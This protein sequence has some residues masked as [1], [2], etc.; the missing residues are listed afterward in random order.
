MS[1]SPAPPASPVS[2]KRKLNE[3]EATKRCSNSKCT[4]QQPMPVSMFYPSKQA[5]TGLDSQCKVCNKTKARQYANTDNGFMRI[6]WRTARAHNARRVGKGR[7]L[8]FTLTFEQ[9]KAKWIAQ[10]GRC[11]YTDMPMVRKPHSHW[12]CSIERVD[13]SKGY[14]DQNTLLCCLETNTSNQFSVAKA[15]YLFSGTKHNRIE[16][17][18]E[19][20]NP[21]VRSGKPVHL[22]KTWIVNDDNTILCHCCGTVKPKTD[23]QK[24]FQGGCKTCVNT[25]NAKYRNT[26][27]G[28]I[29]QIYV[30]AKKNS[31]QRGMAFDLK[32]DHIFDMLKQQG[33]LCYY[34]GVPMSP[35][36]GDYR[37]SLERLD[38]NLTYTKTNAVLICQELNSTDCTRLKTEFSNDGCSG[39]SQSKVQQVIRSRTGTELA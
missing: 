21:P 1:S 14:T 25:R 18:A 32:V 9:L 12:Q 34:S 29:K 10:D 35:S 38:V 26:W 37:M 33:G 22:R 27:W 2:K 24:K 28:A 13:N 8:E 39:W 11:F 31:K 7:K 20:I 17:S 30:N 15:D 36:K 23:F 3:T 4:E 6:L 16:F 19:Q 5:K